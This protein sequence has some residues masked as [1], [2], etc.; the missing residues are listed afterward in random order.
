MKFEKRQRLRRQGI[1]LLPNLFTTLALFFGFYAIIAALKGQ[2]SQACLTV[3]IAM[4]F[5]TLDGRVARMTNTAS[6]FGAEYDSLSDMVTF[7]VA[8]ALIA[9]SWGL[10]QFGKLGWIAAFLYAAATAIRL[11]RFNTQVGRVSKRYFQGLPCPIAAA[12]VTGMIWTGNS[13]GIMP[14]QVNIVNAVITVLMAVLMVS[15][16]PYYSFKEIN[17]KGV[18]SFLMFS[19]VILICVAIAINPPVVLFVSS[20]IFTLSGPI[21]WMFGWG[22]KR[23]LAG[24]QVHTK[25]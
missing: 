18:V 23:H 19:L 6:A 25:K 20:L 2:F 14:E 16:V 5:D 22:R 11:A 24:R 8:P 4:I 7:G 21:T 3:Y 17:F 15:T 12:V 10:N 13:L 9:Y 1:F